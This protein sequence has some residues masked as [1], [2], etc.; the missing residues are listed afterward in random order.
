VLTLEYH[1][2]R[3]PLR[4]PACKLS[5]LLVGKT[6]L[7]LM[8]LRKEGLF[9]LVSCCPCTMPACLSLRFLMHTH[10]LSLSLGHERPGWC[11]PT[12]RC[13]YLPSVTCYRQSI[14]PPPPPPLSLFLL[15]LLLLL[16]M[17]NASASVTVPVLPSPLFP[18]KIILSLSLSLLL[19]LSARDS[20]QEGG[21]ERG[22]EGCGTYEADTHV[23]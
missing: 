20:G 13:A 21:R 10:T 16:S 12:G 14:K 15:L 5:L 3:P 4:A 2:R 22:R 19:L 17:H 6:A 11:Y 23:T 18:N 7:E 9:S 1:A 8:D